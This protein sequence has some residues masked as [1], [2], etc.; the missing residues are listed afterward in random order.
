MTTLVDTCGWI[1]WLIAGS[2]VDLRGPRLR[3][4]EKVFVPI[5]VQF[6]RYRWVRREATETKSLLNDLYGRMVLLN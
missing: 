1:E 2:Q 5:P 6:E 3:T 4:I